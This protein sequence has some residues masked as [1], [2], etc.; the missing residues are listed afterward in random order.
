[1]ASENV[2][3]KKS[4]KKTFL[5]SSLY[6]PYLA[7]CRR[8]KVA[9]E[10]KVSVDLLRKIASHI[11][12]EIRLRLVE[13]EAGVMIDKFGY[14]FVLVSKGHMFRRIG[15]GENAKIFTPEYGG[16]R[17]RV[18]FMPYIKDKNLSF[19]SMDYTTGA[20]V[21][22]EVKDKISK[23]HKYRGYPFSMRK[24]LGMSIEDFVTTDPKSNGK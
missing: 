12:R 5:A 7:Y 4:S 10:D 20:G 3:L 23:G 21:F 1:M 15:A 18:I 17:V 19:W 11:L 2:K 13:N 22:K 24:A 9:K 8:K 16:Q 6:K 14:F